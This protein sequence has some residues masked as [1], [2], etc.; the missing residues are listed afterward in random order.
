[1]AIAQKAKEPIPP[2]RK[3]AAPV[4]IYLDMV[5]LYN[6]VSSKNP[7]YL[8]GRPCQL[9]EAPHEHLVSRVSQ[10]SNRKSARFHVFSSSHTSKD[11]NI[12]K[13][14][15]LK[16]RLPVSPDHRP[17]KPWTRII[18][19]AQS[20]GPLNSRDETAFWD[21]SCNLTLKS[22]SVR[23]P[24]KGHESADDLSKAQQ[25]LQLGRWRILMLE[26]CITRIS[27]LVQPANRPAMPWANRV[28]WGDPVCVFSVIPCRRRNSR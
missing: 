19:F 15:L 11:R 26:L 20:T 22:R 18:R 5:R 10:I 23:T 21:W 9:G 2:E 27:Y 6:N 7:V 12:Q 4:L 3:L 8:I 25:V 1:M 17:P 13:K 14:L 24:R 28:R 16:A